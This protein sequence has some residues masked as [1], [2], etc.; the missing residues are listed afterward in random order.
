V[1]DRAAERRQPEPEEREKHLAD[2][3]GPGV[4]GG[5]GHPRIVSR[6]AERMIE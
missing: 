3:T 1:G 5:G 4:G 6:A 2:A